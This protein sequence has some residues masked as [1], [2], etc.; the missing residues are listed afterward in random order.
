MFKV[1]VATLAMSVA[2]WL[3]WHR[4]AGAGRSADWLAVFGLIPLGVLVYAVVLW[5]LRIEGR[6]EFEAMFRQAVFG[7]KKA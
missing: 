4:L 6:E 5:T 1:F 3:G 2:V 7:R